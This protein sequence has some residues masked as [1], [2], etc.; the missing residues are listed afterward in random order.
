MDR[1][2][3]PRDKVCAGWVTPAVLEARELAPAEYRNAGLV[4]QELNGFR[5]GVIGGESTETKYDDVVSFGVRRCELHD[6]ALE[7]PTG[8]RH[9]AARV[10]HRRDAWIGV[11]VEEL[12]DQCHDLGAGLTQLV[13]WMPW[14]AWRGNNSC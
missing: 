9:I 7:R 6:A 10:Q 1:A 5:T 11:L 14:R 2:R 8:A 13:S 3:F 12:I 4:L